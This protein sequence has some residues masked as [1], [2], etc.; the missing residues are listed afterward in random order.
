MLGPNYFWRVKK[1][2]KIK[3]PYEKDSEVSDFEINKLFHQSLKALNQRKK[4]YNLIA[5]SR[6][7]E[8]EAE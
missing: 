2:S 1:L 7:S 3:Y 4:Q 6:I 5:K 8:T